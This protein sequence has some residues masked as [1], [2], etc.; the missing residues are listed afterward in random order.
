M[1]H[2]EI[3]LAREVTFRKAVFNSKD[4][5]RDVWSERSDGR[6]RMLPYRVNVYSWWP[7]VCM[8]RHPEITKTFAKYND[9]A[10]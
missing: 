3:T 2:G 4:G 5:V 1:K 10:D 6:F 8:A 7:S 9:P